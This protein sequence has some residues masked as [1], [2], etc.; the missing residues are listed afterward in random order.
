[1]DVS[2]LY[3]ITNQH[4]TDIRELRGN[5]DT[6]YETLNSEI[7]NINS[8]VLRQ[9]TEINVRINNIDIMRIISIIFIYRLIN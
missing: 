5:L 9:I 6:L 1:M 3:D 8:T 4:D 7:D 2:T